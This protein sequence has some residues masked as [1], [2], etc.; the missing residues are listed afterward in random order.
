[1]GRGISFAGTAA[2]FTANFTPGTCSLDPTRLCIDNT[3]CNL[4]GFDQT[5]KGMCVG[6][7]AGTVNGNTVGLLA[8]GNW[9]DGTFD[10]TALFGGN[11]DDFSFRGNFVEG[12]G[13]TVSGIA[14]QG[15]ALNGTVQHNVVNGVGNALFFG[16]PSALTWLISLNDF[17]GY[18]TAVR[19]TNDY[20]LPT[21]L[22]GNYWGLLCPGFDP[23]PVRYESGL[24]NPFV[25]DS[26]AYNVPVAATPD[27][28]LPA[29]CQ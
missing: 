6:A 5:S 18:L 8:E 9:L 7:V 19:T 27:A 11:T 24:V 29:S 21:D 16:R 14:L 3:D 17:T 15:T 4:A 23:S 2:V 26:R 22:G 25:T 13:A 1:M 20:N 12:G 10:N 28:Q